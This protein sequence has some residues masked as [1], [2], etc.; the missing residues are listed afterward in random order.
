VKEKETGE[1]GRKEDT[2]FF[3]ALT[4]LTKSRERFFSEAPLEPSTSSASPGDKLDDAAL[5]RG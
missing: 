4:R 5:T 1:R 2:P 3:V